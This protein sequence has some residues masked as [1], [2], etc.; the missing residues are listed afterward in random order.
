[1]R[2]CKTRDI[3]AALLKKGFEERSS[4]HKI[5]YLCIDGKISGVHTFLSHGIK[6]YNVD[7]LAKMRI[8][9]HLSGK[10]LDDLIR[11]PLSGEDYAKLLIERGVFEK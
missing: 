9:L 7:L 10:E 8:Q 3:A 5:F 6:E 11:C 1:M 4:R 2:S